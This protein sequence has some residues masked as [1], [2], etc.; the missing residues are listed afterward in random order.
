[1]VVRKCP[2]HGA[3]P[4]VSFKKRGS[5]PF[6]DTMDQPVCKGT[7]ARRGDWVERF[8]LAPRLP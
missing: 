8:F 2:C 4:G 3:P 1:M 6:E 7:A 5:T